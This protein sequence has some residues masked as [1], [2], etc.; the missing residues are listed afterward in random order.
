MKAKAAVAD[1]RGG[2]RGGAGGGWGGWGGG[3][4]GVGPG[5]AEGVAI[6]F[7][8]GCIW[9]CCVMTGYGSVVNAGR[10]EAG[11]LVVVIG[12]GAVGLC[13]IQAARIAGAGM[14]IAID[15]NASKLAHA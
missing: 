6:L 1:G 12:A 9:G 8:T 10:V 13:C 7:T 14:I 11:A 5:C 4:E 2:V 15:V 3:R